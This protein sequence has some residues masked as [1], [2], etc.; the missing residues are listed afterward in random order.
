M[1]DERDREFAEKF[2]LPIIDRP[3]LE[4]SKVLSKTQGKI[5]KRYKMGCYFCETKILG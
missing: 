1:H 5:V 4:V 3:L 2:D